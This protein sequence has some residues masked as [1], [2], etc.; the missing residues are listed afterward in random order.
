MSG[1]GD[2]TTNSAHGGEH[3]AE[4][5][6]I[7]DEIKQLG[8]GSYDDAI[9]QIVNI[10]LVVAV[11][12][13]VLAGVE[14]VMPDILT[15]F[16]ANKLRT[17]MLA[18]VVLP[19]LLQQIRKAVTD[20]VDTKVG[21]NVAVAAVLAYVLLFHSGNDLL[22]KRLFDSPMDMVGMG[23]SSGMMGP[24]G[25]RRLRP[26]MPAPMPAMPAPMGSNSSMYY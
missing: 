3:G 10:S 22:G 12:Y 7:P 2:H 16:M 13:V 24:M 15:D 26:A 14:Y 21:R 25:P 4:L 18:A 8:L 11:V 9:K 1:C 20:G 19:I 6:A 5:F 23:S 17:A